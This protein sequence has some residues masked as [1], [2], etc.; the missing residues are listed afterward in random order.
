MPQPYKGRR[1][2]LTVR[3]PVDV[4]AEAARRAAARRWNLST[5]IGYCV[6]NQQNPQRARATERGLDPEAVE[7]TAAGLRSRRRRALRAV[8]GHDE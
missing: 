8:S 6:E 4:H 7:L 1:V 5:Y 2:K 3:L